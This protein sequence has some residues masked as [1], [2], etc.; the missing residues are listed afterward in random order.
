MEIF[1]GLIDRLKETWRFARGTRRF[2]EEVSV[3]RAVEELVWKV[4]GVSSVDCI[5]QPRAAVRRV[6]AV[7]SIFGVMMGLWRGDL[8]T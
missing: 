1:D 3:D 5:L 6:G 4:H 2:T 7:P 8:L